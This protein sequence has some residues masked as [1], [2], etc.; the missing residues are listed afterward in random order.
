VHDTAYS[1]VVVDPVGFGLAMMLQLAAVRGFI[2]AGRERGVREIVTLAELWAS[3]LL[4]A[5]T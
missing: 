1:V 5:L 4:I 3:T 2:A